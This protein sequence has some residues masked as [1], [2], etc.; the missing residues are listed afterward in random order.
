MSYN[1][2]IHSN[3]PGRRGELCF[4]LTGVSSDSHI[5][6][7]KQWRTHYGKEMG[8]TLDKNT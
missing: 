3:G 8:S 4:E 2:P 1:E 6:D 7:L 5:K